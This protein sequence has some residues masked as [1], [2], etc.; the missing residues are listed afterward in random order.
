M[1]Q[2]DK[3]KRLVDQRV[4]DALS[5]LKVELKSTSD[6]LTVKLSLDTKEIS[7][8]FQSSTTIGWNMLHFYNA[9]FRSH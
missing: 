9:H 5:K 1:L 7:K 4:N 8:S 6:G 2:E 3:I